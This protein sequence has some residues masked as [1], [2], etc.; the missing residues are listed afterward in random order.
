VKTLAAHPRV[1]GVS[2]V[3]FAASAAI[4][5][6]WCGS[7]A[8]MPGMEMPGGWTMSMAW[9]RMPGQSWPGAAATFIGMWTVMMVAMMLPAL[10][11]M[12]IR[13]RQAVAPSPPHLGW[14]TI[15][16]GAGYFAVWTA[17]GAV[18]YP[19]GAVLAEMAM[20]SSAFARAIP[21][22]TGL[23]VLLA[24]GLQFTAWK[25]RQLACCRAVSR[26]PLQGTPATAF[27]HGFHL[28]MRCVRCCLGLSAIL[29]VTGV[30]DLRA[31]ALV[32]VAITLE[33]ISCGAGRGVA[34][35]GACAVACGIALVASAVM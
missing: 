29:L 21:V 13:Y 23:I 2:A 3:L 18:V 33:R 17:C 12:L 20:R 31:M 4:T 7:M 27:C 26:Q 28:G 32:T 34:A 10:T 16:A 24:G 14:L 5:V 15:L 11:P 35:I 19:V 22:A 25:S 1:L 9:M 6:T 8:A 30:M